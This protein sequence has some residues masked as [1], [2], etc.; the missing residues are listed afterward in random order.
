MPPVGTHDM[1]TDISSKSM[2]YLLL[3][4]ILDHGLLFI[5]VEKTDDNLLNEAT[6]SHR[7]KMR[8]YVAVLCLMFIF[9]YQVTSRVGRRGTLQK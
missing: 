8:E 1:Q 9:F 5:V 3:G 6:F 4:Y 7:E 2:S